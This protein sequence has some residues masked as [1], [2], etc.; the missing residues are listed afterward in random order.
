MI[1]EGNF[2]E[3][4]PLPSVVGGQPSRSGLGAHSSNCTQQ[5]VTTNS[6]DQF[7]NIVRH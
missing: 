3:S 7:E 6:G 5:E 4:A 2:I 1:L